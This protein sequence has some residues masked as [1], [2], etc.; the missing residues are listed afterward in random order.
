MR[1]NHIPVFEGAGG[2]KGGKEPR[3]APDSLFSNQ[4]AHVLDLLS[5]GEIEG[6][7]GETAN[8]VMQ[9]VF[10]NEVPIR[11]ANGTQ[12]FR[13]V[14]FYAN[15]GTPDQSAIP[16][17]DDVKTTVS[18]A[19]ELPY[20]VYKTISFVNDGSVTAVLVT[21]ATDAF[22]EVEKDG[23]QVGTDCSFVIEISENGGPFEVVHNGNIRGK[24]RDGFK[25]DYRITVADPYGNTAVRVKR[26]KPD[27]G[28]LKINDAI[29]FETYTK[30][31]EHT[32]SYP[33]LAVAGHVIDAKQFG[34]QIPQRQYRVRGIKC[35]IPHNYDPVTRTYTG[36]FN[37]TL[38]TE[39]YYTNCGPWVLYE[40]LTNKRFG[41]GELFDE[42]YIDIPTL[43]QT[44]K[45]ADE[46]VPDGKGGQEPRWT[47][48]TVITSRGEAFNVLKELVSNFRA[49]LYW[50]QM[51]L[52]AIGDA[53]RDP[54]KVVTNANVLDG[55][56]TRSGE[57][58]A[59]R[60]SVVNVSWNDPDIFMRRAIESVEDPKLIREIGYKTKDFGA[61]G[62]TSR[63]Q[64][65][66]LGRAI[67]FSQEFES[68][69]IS[70]R[71]SYDHMAVEDSSF[72]GPDGLAPGDVIV[73]CDRENGNAVA[74]GRVKN[75]AGSVLTGSD[76]SNE[77]SGSGTVYIE[78]AADGSIELLTCDYDGATITL[79]EA[80]VQ[81]VAKND[82]YIVLADGFTPELAV[83]LKIEEEEQ[84]VLG[85][86]CVR[87]D[88]DRE[89]AIYQD[90][91]IDTT[92]YMTLP[93]ADSV[94][95][96]SNLRTADRFVTGVDEY[97]RLI[98]VQMDES[99]DPFLSHY[100]VRYSF[101]NADWVT[102][103]PSGSPDMSI[104]GVKPGVYRIQ[105]MAVNSV[106]LYSDYVEVE[107]TVLAVPDD[108]TLPPGDIANL[109]LQGG[110]TEWGGK[111]LRC[112]WEL[113][114][115]VSGYTFEVGI[116]TAEEIDGVVDAMFR[117]CRITVRRADNSQVLRVDS[118]VGTDYN[119]TFE[120][121]H[122]DTNGA[123]V[124]N[125]IIGV[126][127]R[128]KYGRLSAER[129]INVSNPAPVL[130]SSPEVEAGLDAIRVKIDR[131]ADIDFGG[132]KVYAKLVASPGE[133]V[134][135]ANLRYEG[136]N[137]VAEFPSIDDR[138]HTL[139]VVP[140]DF[141]GDGTPSNGLQVTPIGILSNFD[142]LSEQ[143]E[144]LGELEELS[145]DGILTPHEKITRLLP[146]QARLSAL[147]TLL[148]GQAEA[149]VD[150][151]VDTAQVAAET[152]YN[153]W[154][155]YLSSL[156]PAWNDITQRTTIERTTFNTLSINL[157]IK[158]NDLVA[159]LRDQAAQVALWSNV[160]DDDGSRPD[161]YSNRSVGGQQLRDTSFFSTFWDLAGN[162]VRALFAPASYD[163]ALEIPAEVGVARY[164][165]PGASNLVAVEQDV[166]IFVAFRAHADRHGVRQLF[167]SDGSKIIGDDGEEMYD[168]SFEDANWNLKTK[169][170]WYD[171]NKVEI[172]QTDLI[173]LP[174]GAQSFQTFG[175][176]PPVGARFAAIAFGHDDDLAAD[177]T[178]GWSVSDPWMAY[179]QH[180]ADVT[181]QNDRTISAPPDQIV[182]VDPSGVPLDG[183][184][185]RTLQYVRAR[186]DEDVSGE[187][188][189]GVSLNNLVGTIST[190]GLLTITAI[191]GDNAA[192]IVTNTADDGE[193]A[194]TVL[195]TKQYTE[196]ES[197]TSGGGAGGGTGVAKTSVNFG[198]L[199]TGLTYGGAG[200]QTA[201]AT[202][203]SDG[204]LK[205]I[206]NQE[207]WHAVASSGQ[208]GS[209]RIAGRARYSPA[210]ANTWTEFAAETL[211][212]YAWSDS[213]N[214]FEPDI[215][216]NG[217]LNFTHTVTGLTAGDY[218]VE[219]ELRLVNA[220]NGNPRSF[221]T[222]TLSDGS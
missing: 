221:G 24:Q 105:G 34:N 12:N 1:D 11:D 196:E 78:H 169:L 108:Q 166:R 192:A 58:D 4:T 117:D 84:N 42:S 132:M 198:G 135:A 121:N 51:R 56:F 164:S 93:K 213:A 203:N 118:V 79:T 82:Q 45:F 62:C 2:G 50:M 61:F 126:Q 106:G 217:D 122:E 25:R 189:W 163:Y 6:I 211:G 187:G 125:V 207:Y 161:P 107:H 27:P 111:H 145:D 8:E 215:G 98:D 55:K 109:R 180:A 80:S 97:A 171:E 160:E 19:Q 15:N 134:T 218:D 44:G 115:P 191:E 86:S 214:R 17:F 32:L 100:V 59:Q 140:F 136:P 68:E 205:V 75:V 26:T 190:T 13:G 48:N 90:E 179:H 91:H 168:D 120:M 146:T 159:A 7:V 194:D 43:Y 216:V 99:E 112:R 9:S 110:G 36:A 39:K 193:L 208:G 144:E 165:T 185:P 63:G 155:A 35:R 21:I 40:I 85:V 147:W 94:L 176:V 148:D 128:D 60:V 139:V 130:A 18:V 158:L 174:P 116:D 149:I 74:G 77:T 113:T 89:A 31:V 138:P 220:V 195:F 96:P 83:V 204:T 154:D 178:G 212:S 172:S 184:L 170:I 175:K 219:V 20:N 14:T 3:E 49:S 70:Y 72:G 71:A 29:K 141:Y 47:C 151:A 133:T 129:Q 101:N 37:G 181:S 65:R 209:S 54:V 46:L 41:L 73:I 201:T 124:R 38:T 188:V 137:T 142:A 104:R 53:P 183:Q 102:L 202:V 76:T 57:S 157:E 119:Y 30:V 197:S 81:P 156:A 177:A 150:D 114:S 88:E 131:P 92:N 162:H 182:R 210:G 66:R 33:N 143:V 67:L 95:P 167:A 22:F 16:G 5:E 127:Y 153:A 64:A 52:W 69:M 200:T 23:D 222:A 152:A 28:S 123:P 10:Y 87:W 186:G 206:V 173:T 103:S 199:V